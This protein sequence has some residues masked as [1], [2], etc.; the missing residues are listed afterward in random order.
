[1]IKYPVQLPL[2]SIYFCRAIISRI[3][4]MTSSTAQQCREDIW[5]FF[6]P[7]STRTR[8]ARNWKLLFLKLLGHR[9]E[10][11]H[12]CGSSS[13]SLIRY[14]Q[15]TAAILTSPMT[16]SITSS[17]TLSSV[18]LERRGGESAITAW[19]RQVACSLLQWEIKTHLPRF[20]IICQLL[21]KICINF[22]REEIVL[23]RNK[24]ILE[25]DRTAEECVK[26]SIAKWVSA[27][28]KLGQR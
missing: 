15:L 16:E 5:L 19:A 11:M 26:S 25:Q 20:S 23:V 21:V 3:P 13:S 14:W 22:G 9:H 10:I 6:L 2:N 1:M 27:G 12:R 18:H 7:L 8:I 4:T 17:K 24:S 28:T